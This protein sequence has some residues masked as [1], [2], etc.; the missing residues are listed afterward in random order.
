M[1]AVKAMICDQDLPLHLWAKAT[2]T[3]SY[4][5]NETPHC[6]LENK[7]LEEMFTRDKL[8]V[9]HLRIFGR[10]IYIHIPK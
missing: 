2:R 5:H 4:L 9:N 10:P 7:T 1:E 3:T 6:V 8:E